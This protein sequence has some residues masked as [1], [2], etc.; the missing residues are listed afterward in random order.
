MSRACQIQASNCSA[1]QK[2]EQRRKIVEFN[3]ALRVVLV[4][5]RSEYKSAGLNPTLWW[6]SSDYFGFQQSAHSEIMLLSSFEKIDTKTARRKL[7]QPCEG[8]DRTSELVQHACSPTHS[9]SNTAGDFFWEDIENDDNT[10]PAPT[11]TSSPRPIKRSGVRSVSSLDCI[12]AALRK[13]SLDSLDALDTEDT[14]ALCVPLKETCTISF[15]TKK[16]SRRRSGK[17]ILPVGSPLAAVIAFI[18]AILLAIIVMSDH[19]S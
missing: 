9:R 19:S 15:E 13:E 18:S 8:D 6:N 14:I 3:N 7:Y 5:T 12:S 11:S 1:E 17:H 16:G 10:T 4:P 2:V